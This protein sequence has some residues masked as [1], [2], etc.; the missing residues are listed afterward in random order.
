MLLPR[1]FTQNRKLESSKFYPCMLIKLLNVLYLGLN[2][3]FLTIKYQFIQYLLLRYAK[4]YQRHTRGPSIRTMKLFTSNP[5]FLSNWVRRPS[6]LIC[7]IRMSS[8]GSYSIQLPK[9][10]T[11][12]CSLKICSNVSV[13]PISIVIVLTPR[14]TQAKVDSATMVK[15]MMLRVWLL[16]F[17]TS[18]LC[19]M[20]GRTWL[21][22]LTK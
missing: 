13:V 7:P 10:F 4:L 1:Q 8:Q 17:K 5:L 18:E 22:I 6:G 9:K 16:N 15:S 20:T 2:K 11:K 21:Q 3:C 19:L 12:N 14:K